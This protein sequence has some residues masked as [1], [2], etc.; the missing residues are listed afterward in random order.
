E[1]HVPC[2]IAD[3]HDQPGSRSEHQNREADPPQSQ[4]G[5]GTNH[6]QP[7]GDDDF[8]GGLATLERLVRDLDLP[9]VVKETGCGLS[10]HVGSR[11]SDLG[12][13][14]ADVGGAGGT[15][16]VGVEALR[17]EDE[18]RALGEGYWD[19]GI[20]TAASVAQLSGLGLGIC[21]TGGVSDGLSIARAMSLGARCGG[22]ARPFLQAHTQGG[23]DLVQQL[24]ERIIREIRVACLLTGCRTPSELSHRP[25]VVG[26]R[27]ARWIPSGTPLAERTRTGNPLPTRTG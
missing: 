17:A 8:R 9:L 11:I 10:R 18:D 1:D 25:I 3:R 15:S 20:P 4:E 26:D 7:E 24:A 27:L 13:A 6:A 21:A 19:W 2:R 23:R 16:W 12:I 5:A 22:V 14:W